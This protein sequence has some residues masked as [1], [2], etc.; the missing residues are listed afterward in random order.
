MPR[1][2][3][4]GTAQCPAAMSR[5]ARIS[6]RRWWQNTWEAGTIA[7]LHT[8][9]QHTTTTMTEAPSR[10]WAIRPCLHPT[11][12]TTETPPTLQVRSC[13]HMLHSVVHY[14]GDPGYTCKRVICWQLSTFFSSSV[15][16][17]LQWKLAQPH[18][19]WRW[20]VGI[21]HAHACATDLLPQYSPLQPLRPQQVRKKS[22]SSLSTKPLPDPHYPQS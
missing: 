15:L 6:R 7:T 5:L 10:A 17:V 19:W 13:H 1:C 9:R 14:V 16:S 20:Y 21:W 22:F 2:D 18:D 3:H 8:N 11:A 4:P 12:T